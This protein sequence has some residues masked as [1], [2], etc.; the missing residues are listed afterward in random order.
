MNTAQQPRTR[1]CLPFRILPLILAAVFLLSACGSA[2]DRWQEA[3]DRGV[4]FLEEG[5]FEEA[6]IAFQA[7]IELDPKR[8]DAYIGL[9]DALEGHGDVEEA[10][11]VLA[12]ALSVVEDATVIQTRLDVLDGKSPESPDS[13]ASPGDGSSSASASTQTPDVSAEPAP[14]WQELYDKG[15]GCLQNADYAGAG[16]AF[17]GAIGLDATNAAA[18]IGL[19]DAYVGQNAKDSA[20][21]MLQNALNVVSDPA[22]IQSKL[23]EINPPPPP[24]PNPAELLASVTYYGDVS[25]CA[26]TP[27]QAGKMAQTLQNWSGSMADL[28]G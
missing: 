27:A 17:N 15:M 26:L 10:R 2:E 3:Y 8:A 14:T 22:A 28:Y 9:A 7:A 5:N 20:I 1:R 11:K 18:Y 21:Q 4:R 16:E 13:S 6:A 12:D 25:K 24:A 19:A 23:D